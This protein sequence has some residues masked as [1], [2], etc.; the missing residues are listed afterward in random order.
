MLKMSTSEL[1]FKDLSLRLKHFILFKWNHMKT[2]P[3]IL[4]V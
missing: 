1:R 4:S 2:F 3:T